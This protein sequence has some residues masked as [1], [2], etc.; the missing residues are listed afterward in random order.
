MDYIRYHETKQNNSSA[1]HQFLNVSQGSSEEKRERK[2]ER[3]GQENSLNLFSLKPKLK[4]DVVE[5]QLAH[6]YSSVSL[7]SKSQIKIFNMMNPNSHLDKKKT[8]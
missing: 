5:N 7:V 2:R 3:R 1:C 4:Q 6:L 8:L